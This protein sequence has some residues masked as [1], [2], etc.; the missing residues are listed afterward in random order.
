MGQNPTIIYKC[1]NKTNILVRYGKSRVPS[2][3]PQFPQVVQLV[4]SNDVVTACHVATKLTVSY[5]V[6]ERNHVQYVLIRVTMVT[7]G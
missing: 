6:R 5:V 4:V 7:W 1:I 3:G 2:I